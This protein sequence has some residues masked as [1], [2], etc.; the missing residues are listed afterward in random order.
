MIG[1][2]SGKTTTMRAIR[3][4]F[5]VLMVVLLLVS[6]LLV[7]I[8]PAAAEDSTPQ[9]IIPADAV[10]TLSSTQQRTSAGN[11]FVVKLRRD[12]AEPGLA[13]D[14]I[15]ARTGITITH[16]Y[17]NSMRGFSAIVAPSQLEALRSMRDVRS[18]EPVT[19]V[20]LDAQTIPPG[21]S[22]IEASPANKN[23]TA[24]VDGIDDVRVD[25]DVAVIDSGISS[26][27]PD[28]NYAGG[29]DCTGNNA[30]GS[31]QV[32]HGTHVA[33]TIGALDNGIGVVGVAPGVRLWSVRV[34]GATG[35]T[36]TDIIYCGLEHIAVNAAIYDVANMSLGGGGGDSANCSGTYHTYICNAVNAGVTI[37]VAAGNSASDSQWFLPAAFDEVITVSAMSD[38]NGQ[39]S[40]DDSFASF[41]N[42]GA[43]VDIAAPGVN[44]LS[45]YPGNAYATMSGTS[46]ATPHVAGAAALY[47]ATH[48]AATPAEVRAWI[49]ANR[50]DVRISGDRDAINE[51]ILNVNDGEPWGVAPGPTATPGPTSTPLP[52]ATPAP[53]PGNDDIAS[54]IVVSAPY[55]STATQTTVGATTA[56]SDPVACTAYSSSVWYRFTVQ[57]DGT[58]RITTEGS[59]FDT[60][61]AVYQG[62]PGALTSVA[63]NDDTVGV[64]SSVQFT[65]SASTTYYVMIGSWA[66]SRPGSLR[67]VVDAPDPSTTPT[68]TAT[69]R[70]APANDL[71]SG[72]MVLGGAFPISTSQSTLGATTSSDDPSSC[73]PHSSTVWFTLTPA[74]GTRI[75]GAT[76]GSNFDTV[77]AVYTQTSAGLVLVACNDDV[78]N[79]DRSSIVNFNPTAGTTYVVM[80]ASYGDSTAGSLNLAFTQTTPTPTPVPPTATPVPPTATPVPPTSTPIPP[81]ETPVPPTATPLPITE[82]PVQP[83]ATPEPSATPTEPIETPTPSPTTAPT[84]TPTV[85]APTATSVP[86]TLTPTPNPDTME[87]TAEF[88]GLSN[89]M[90]VQRLDSVVVSAQDAAPGRVAQVEVYLC[91]T[92]GCDPLSPTQGRVVGIDRRQ[93][94]VF[95][96]RPA[97]RGGTVVMVAKATDA[98]GNIGFSEPITVFI[99]RTRT[100]DASSTCTVSV[101]GLQLVPAKTDKANHRDRG[102]RADRRG[103]GATLCDGST[104][105]TSTVDDQTATHRGDRRATHRRTR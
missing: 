83:T 84:L 24:D 51:G 58:T 78:S 31:D 27:H 32:G 43:D 42:Y 22:R 87:P 60:L 73:A 23:A 61:L 101:D 29:I 49:V 68:P 11:R 104:T 66:T 96:F 97:L 18:V 16:V 13:A 77:L 12:S 75:T 9:L 59:D 52:T 26:S 90:R 62:A 1:I 39:P 86:P 70:P 100:A 64:S 3:R 53:A 57:A 30:P 46:M 19:V 103:K 25:A 17:R 102:D 8:R 98:S 40:S 33:G 7:T 65:A 74:L 92:V 41:S 4:S 76:A 89:G 88:V 14:R 63:C 80:I 105:S 6:Q 94:Y 21:I 47:R 95:Q 72:A 91:A 48:P 44:V 81:T 34:F 67:L 2:S 99:G 5:L 55:P 56:A 82:T 35:S 20:T 50:E 28:L 37:A 79:G 38:S 10:R 15:A 69:P 85:P 71:R 93:P 54:A 45:T 36:T